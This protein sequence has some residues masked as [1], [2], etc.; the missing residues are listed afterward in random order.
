MDIKTFTPTTITEE[1]LKELRESTVNVNPMDQ[2]VTEESGGMKADGNK[3]RPELFPLETMMAI[4]DVLT[5]GAEKYEDNNWKKV[6]PERYKGALLRH[7]AAIEAGEV[8][9][10]DSGLPHIDHCLLY[11]SPS[12]RD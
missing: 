3:I 9:D 5:F 8:I 11:T 10:P 1:Q 7:L 6:N 12:P 4:S 2:L